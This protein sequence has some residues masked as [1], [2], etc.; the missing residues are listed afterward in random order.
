MPVQAA[1]TGYRSGLIAI[2]PTM[3]VGLSLRTASP[4]ITPAAAMSTR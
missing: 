3:S 1:V 2:A 4:A